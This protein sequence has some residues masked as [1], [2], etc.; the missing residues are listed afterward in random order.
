MAQ[1]IGLLLVGC[2]LIAGVIVAFAI[3]WF[4]FR[5]RK[6]K[7]NSARDLAI[8]PNTKPR[9]ARTIIL[10]ENIH[11]QNKLN[12]INRRNL[13]IT[14]P[15][16]VKQI[17]SKKPNLSYDVQS[18]NT[19][20][21]APIANETILLSTSTKNQRIQRNPTALESTSDINRVGSKSRKAKALK[22]PISVGTVDILKQQ[23]NFSSKK[24]DDFVTMMV[25]KQTLD[26]N[27][28][29]SSNSNNQRT[30]EVFIEMSEDMKLEKVKHSIEKVNKLQD[31]IRRNK[32]HSSRWLAEIEKNMK[33]AI[34]PW[35]GKPIPFETNVLDVDGEDFD[36]LG[37]E[38]RD[39][40][41]QVC[42]DISLA[43]QIVWLWNELNNPSID[44]QITYRSLAF[45]IADQLIK[46]V[47]Q[48]STGSS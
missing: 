31:Q 19:K 33:V 41:I 30:Q 32:R 38:E 48:I 45:K 17:I 28:S 18:Q 29:K 1:W 43:N 9:L 46:I 11:G 40:L 6:Q 23:N 20:K 5:L 12:R 34:T 42:V 3:R 25:V 22:S 15:D 2:A 39:E 10:T 13:V 24:N 26:V 8:I 21:P 44:L 4:V 47:E 35:G 14:P 37:P 36:V 7:S 16:S 27:H